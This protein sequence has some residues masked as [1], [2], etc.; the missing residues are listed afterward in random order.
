MIKTEINRCTDNNGNL[1]IC[2]H[3]QVW[4]KEQYIFVG[5]HL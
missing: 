1:L 4:T 2:L 5:T 3:I